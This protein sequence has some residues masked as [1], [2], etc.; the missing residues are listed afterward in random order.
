MLV[1]LS[2]LHLTDGSC[3]DTIHPDA[4][5][6]FTGILENMAK[7][8][9][10][11]EINLVFLGDIF[12]LIRSNHWFDSNIRPW[13]C[14][15][16]KEIELRD[17]TIDIFRKIIKNAFNNSSRNHLLSLKNRMKS[18]GI[19]MH[20]SYLPGNHDWLINQ[21]PETRIM[22]ARFFDMPD[23]ENYGREQFATECFFKEY[24]VIARHGDIFDPLNYDGD[25]NASSIGDAVVIELE[26]R[27]S[28]IVKQESSLQSEPGLIS[29]LQEIDNVRPV[30]DV[31]LW[32]RGACST[33][34]SNKSQKKVHEIWNDLVDDFIKKD[35]C[36]QYGG[37]WKI[38]T[39]AALYL[40]LALSKQTPA[41]RGVADIFKKNVIPFF[42]RGDDNDKNAFYEKHLLDNRAEFTVY[43]H[44]HLYKI[45]PLDKVFANGRLL[46]KTYFN[47]GTWKKVHVNTAFSAMQFLSWHVM[48]F[49]AFYL[50]K[51]RGKRKFEV[52]NG[53]LG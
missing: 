23:P 45:Q 17:R 50:K 36:R 37:K 24:K 7:T 46:E 3:G 25:R 2:D 31:P 27:F 29:L 47:T 53:A 26:N 33:A 16:Q 10:A 44:T 51:E 38:K 52:W 34:A 41:I 6:K 35:L 22:A 1:F 19:P 12:D 9:A 32:I 43:G 20:F 49:I 4:F 14:E 5:D 48:T 8:A 42:R 39:R 18:M 13:S 21:F 40:T 11:E 28:F 15:P 30:W